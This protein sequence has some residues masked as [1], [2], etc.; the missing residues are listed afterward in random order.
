MLRGDVWD[1]WSRTGEVRVRESG[2]VCGARDDDIHYG[3]VVV[4]VCVISVCV[5]MCLDWLP[6]QTGLGEVLC[7]VIH[8]LPLFLVKKCEHTSCR[9]VSV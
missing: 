3:V 1:C 7:S 6:V 9:C 4:V 8:G 2:I 5:C